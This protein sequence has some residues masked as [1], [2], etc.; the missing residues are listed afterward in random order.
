MS[1][2]SKIGDVLYNK[3][4]KNITTRTF[5]LITRSYKQDIYN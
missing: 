2:A 3:K 5:I 4:V 1:E